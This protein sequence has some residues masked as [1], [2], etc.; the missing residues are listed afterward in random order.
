MSTR[1]TAFAWAVFSAPNAGSALTIQ[2]FSCRMIRLNAQPPSRATAT[3]VSTQLA[4]S[5]DSPAKAQS[6]AM[7]TA[8]RARI[9]PSLGAAHRWGCRSRTFNASAMR[10]A[11]VQASYRSRAPSSTHRNRR[12]GSC[13]RRPLS[14]TP[15]DQRPARPAGR[16]PR[17]LTIEAFCFP[18]RRAAH[19][20]FP[21]T[22]PPRRARSRWRR[23]ARRLRPGRTWRPPRRLAGARHPRI[24][25][26]QHGRTHG[27]PAAG[28]PLGRR[29][30]DR[31]R[32]RSGALLPPAPQLGVG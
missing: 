31:P 12:R 9:R 30:D 21:E 14:S 27:V 28:Q 7:R 10:P 32:D 4:A 16:R 8:C 24:L 20:H 29:R 18:Q 13:R 15:R 6:V 26:H 2:R 5:F 3:W 19:G 11:A 23:P 25:G 17:R 22:H 1:R